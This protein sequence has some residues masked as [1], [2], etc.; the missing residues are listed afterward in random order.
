MAG[1]DGIEAGVPTVIDRN[2]AVF[3]EL[4][5]KSAGAEYILLNAG[6]FFRRALQMSSLAVHECRLLVLLIDSHRSPE[7]QA[8]V[9][10]GDADAH[11]LRWTLAGIRNDPT[12]TTQL[13][14]QRW[15]A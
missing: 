15:A 11:P 2:S 8:F 12:M 14:E 1:L 9:L 7:N 6:F 10:P 5:T 13:R 4:I 3:T